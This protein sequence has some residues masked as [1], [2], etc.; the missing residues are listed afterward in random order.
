MKLEDHKNIYNQ[1]LHKEHVIYDGAN[2]L[3]NCVPSCKV[4]N[5]LKW[6]YELES[7]YKKQDF[8]DEYKLQKIYDW[9]NVCWKD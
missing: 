1:D 3:S 2:D 7:W 8:Y 9:V 5:S 4:C 6:Q